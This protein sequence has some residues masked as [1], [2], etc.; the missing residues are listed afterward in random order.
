[1]RDKGSALI[2]SIIAIMVLFMIFTALI[3]V[4]NYNHS[5]ETS[6]EK[7]LRAY[8]LAEAGTN[9]GIAM[10]KQDVENNHRKNVFS[11]FDNVNYTEQESLTNP[12]GDDYPGEFDIK[13][14][15][16]K[17][18]VVTETVED[19]NGNLTEQII[20][21]SYVITVESTGYYPGRNGIKRTL[22]KQYTFT[23]PPERG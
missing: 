2:T 10:A 16:N 4:V 1:M 12:F 18:E 14:T 5:Y 21:A 13:I 23:S 22:K 6:E 7:G 3:S 9:Y 8:Y 15:M 11:R 17:A 19:E 20:S